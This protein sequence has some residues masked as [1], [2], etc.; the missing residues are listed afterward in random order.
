MTHATPKPMNIVVGIE[1][2]ETGEVAFRSAADIA[3][4]LGATLHLCFAAGPSDEGATAA[5]RRLDHGER[6]L[7]SWASTRLFGDPLIKRTKLYVD[8]GSPAD[9]LRRLAAD[10]EA[11][12]IVVGS[13]GKGALARLTEGS[14][15]HELMKASPC[16]VTVATEV[17]YEPFAT[18][19]AIEASPAPGEAKRKLDAS[20]HYHYRRRVKMNTAQSTV[21]SGAPM[22]H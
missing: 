5:E 8:L 12:M 19:P 9:V 7:A 10:V 14:V 21:G 4:R 20:H 1:L 11:S 22:T 3:R 13:H 17:D 16:P 6:A 15:V 18:S 2:D